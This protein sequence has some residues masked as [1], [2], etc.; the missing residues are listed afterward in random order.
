MELAEVCPK[1]GCTGVYKVEEYKYIRRCG[2]CKFIFSYET[3]QLSYWGTIFS[4]GTGWT[5]VPEGC[6]CIM[7]YRQIEE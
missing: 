6:L 5:E 4:G 2:L 3:A 1:C 7:D